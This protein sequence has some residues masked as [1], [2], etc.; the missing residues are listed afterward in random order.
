MRARIFAVAALALFLAATAHAQVARQDVFWARSTGGAA[1]TLDGLLNEPAWAQAESLKIRWQQDTGIP[2][3][4]YKAEGGILPVDPTRATIKFLTVGNRLYMAAIVPDS[5]IGGSEEFNRFDGILMQFKDKTVVGAHPAPP[6]EFLYSWWYPGTSQN[7]RAVNKLPGFVGKWGNFPPDT[8]RTPT[9]IDNW[10]AV[11]VVTGITN[12]DGI[13]PADSTDKRWVVEMMFNLEGVGYDITDA[14]GDIV[15]FNLSLYDCDW[16][17]TNPLSFFFS[18][19]RTWWQGPWGNS[20]GYNSVRLFARPNVTIASGAVPVVAPEL[21]VP[22]AGNYPV[23]AID[24]QLN[25]QVWSHAPH[26]DIRY[27]DDANF[28]TYPGLGPV[29]SGQYQP[30]IAGNQAFIGDPADATV[31]YFVR[32]D[33]LFLGFDVRDQFVQYS[34]DENLYDGFR[35]SLNEYTLHDLVDHVL[36]GRRL[37]FQV[38]PT[39]QAKTLDYLTTMQDTSGTARVRL[40]LKPGT[41]VDNPPQALDNGYQAELVVNLRGLG[42]PAGLGER[43]LH[44]GITHIDGDQFSAP[45]DTYGARAWWFREYDSTSGPVWAHLSA[46]QFVTGVGDGDP[47][48]AGPSLALLGS[49]PNPFKFGTAVRFSLPREADVRL[50]VYDLQGRHVSRVAGGRLAAGPQQLQVLGQ[51][52]RSGVYL[53]RLRMID[54][55]TGVELASAN[56]R[57]LKVN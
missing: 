11:T 50:D 15:A 26:F 2:G 57:M 1:I 44:W 32:D 12:A 37:T 49:H 14:D 16:F 31:Y 7:P 48:P 33:S 28:A 36:Q 4:G 19:N 30:V 29:L 6:A 8:A 47:T 56:G 23:P 39:G 22:N 34:L 43:R 54:P 10:N 45:E 21:I 55:A 17:W 3:S 35:V 38:G 41:V 25:D 40:F 42:Y 9:Q 24:G 46:T 13:S 27:G 5:S 18:V 20:A 51:S 53:Y 52:W